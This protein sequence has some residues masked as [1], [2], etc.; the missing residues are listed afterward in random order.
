MKRETTE[1]PAAGLPTLTPPPESPSLRRRF[2]AMVKPG[3]SP[4]PP[5]FL[6]SVS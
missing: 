2:H 6:Q 4:G 5:A 3:G 1:W